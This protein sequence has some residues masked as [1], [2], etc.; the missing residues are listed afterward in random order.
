MHFERE[1]RKYT[2]CIRAVHLGRERN[3][4][5]REESFFTIE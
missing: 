5:E 1:E 3:K 2:F 4:E